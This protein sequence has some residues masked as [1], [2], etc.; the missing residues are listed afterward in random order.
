MELEIWGTWIATDDDVPRLIVDAM[1]ESPSDGSIHRALMD[2]G[3]P[4]DVLSD[5]GPCAPPVDEYTRK[6]LAS[7]ALVKQACVA[8]EACGPAEALTM[9]MTSL[10]ALGQRM[11][12]LT[13]Q[14]TD[15]IG[16]E[17]YDGV[18][19]FQQVQ[20]FVSTSPQSH[21]PYTVL[22]VDKCIPN[23]DDLEFMRRPRRFCT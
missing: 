14:K 3:V 7:L 17:D 4:L 9:H 22:K 2:A 12:G 6:T 5:L 1:R 23:I 10:A 21:Y 13:H 8:R 20:P 15:A 11:L 19:Q 18:L 16:R